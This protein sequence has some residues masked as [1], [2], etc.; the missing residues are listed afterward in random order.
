MLGLNGGAR[1]EN[2]FSQAIICASRGVNGRLYTYRDAVVNGLGVDDNDVNV[3]GN[4]H[5]LE[6]GI[7]RRLRISQGRILAVVEPT[8]TIHRS[9]WE[10]AM[11]VLEKYI[12]AEQLHRLVMVDMTRAH[13]RIPATPGVMDGWFLPNPN[14]P[15]EIV[16]SARARGCGV[17]E[18]NGKDGAD[19]TVGI[20]EAIRVWAANVFSSVA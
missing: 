20:T 7:G 18:I 10:D 8:A 13:T 15:H 3:Y 14:G 11:Y 17:I 2:P 19:P 16:S 12:A 5:E 6:D 9:T 1:L 4:V